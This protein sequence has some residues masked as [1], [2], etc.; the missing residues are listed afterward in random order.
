MSKDLEKF[1]ISEMSLRSLYYI[2]SPYTDP[3]PKVREQRV[4]DVST[5]VKHIA[6]NWKNALPF[7][8][9][10]YTSTLVDAGMIDVP[11]GWYHFDVSF[12]RKADVLLILELEGWESSIGVAIESAFA[13]AKGIRILRCTLEELLS[14]DPLQ[15]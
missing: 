1:V 9:V 11:G 6:L 14:G 4:V 12:L 10:L 15:K 5:A 3:D 13:I 2:A 8:P 7:S